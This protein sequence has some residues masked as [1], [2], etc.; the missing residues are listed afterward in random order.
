MKDFNLNKTKIKSGFNVPEDYFTQFESKMMETIPFEDKSKVVSI[1]YKKQ[2]WIS[3]I[4]AIFVAMFAIPFYFNNTNT[5]IE[6]STLENYLATE[7]S[8]Y[9]ITDKLTEEDINALENEVT[10]NDEAIEK[11]LLETQN[12]DYYLNE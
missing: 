4:A 12:L 9:E 6:T 8:T 10:Y 3:A 2:I 11:Y 1:F 7:F 5:T